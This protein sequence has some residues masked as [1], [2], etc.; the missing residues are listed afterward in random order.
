MPTEGDYRQDDEECA[1]RRRRGSRGEG[2]VGRLD[3]FLAPVIDPQ[4]VGPRGG[5]CECQ[6][7]RTA[8]GIV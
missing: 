8:I 1:A 4:D 6:G 2:D 7:E 3:P 5:G